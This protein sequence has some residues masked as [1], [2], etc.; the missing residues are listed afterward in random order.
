MPSESFNV[1][2]KSLQDS[3]SSEAIFKFALASDLLIF[4]A[5]AN[6]ESNLLVMVE[7]YFGTRTEYSF[8]V[9]SLSPQSIFLVETLKVVFLNVASQFVTEDNFIKLSANESIASL[10]GIFNGLPVIL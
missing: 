7:I 8:D 9:L 1:T 2:N 3:S 10:I 6:K 4:S 5:S